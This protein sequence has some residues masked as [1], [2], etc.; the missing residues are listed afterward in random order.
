M[1]SVLFFT[2][3]LSELELPLFFGFS[4]LAG[5]LFALHLVFFVLF[6]Q[7]LLRLRADA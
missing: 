5:E 3:L 4:L 6:L 1:T 7:S 2:L